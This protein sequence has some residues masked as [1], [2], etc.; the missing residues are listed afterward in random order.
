MF[1]PSEKAELFNNY[2]YE[3]F[4]GPSDY[5]INIGWS[6]DQVFDIDLD[7][8]KVRK[9]LF[10]IKSNKASGPDGIH[11]KISSFTT[12][13]NFVQHMQLTKRLEDCQCRSYPQKR[14]QRRYQK[15]S[16]YF[17]NKSSY[18][19][20]ERILKEKLLIRTSHLLDCRQH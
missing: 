10:N 19:N 5:N 6:N 13:Q 14:K 16:P 11:S 2:F 7:Q 4:S 20:F 17:T 12:L 9:L 8:N 1:K 18:E 3:Q 15:L